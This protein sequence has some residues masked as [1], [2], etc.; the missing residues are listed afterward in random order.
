[1]PVHVHVCNVHTYIYI[2]IHALVVVVVVLAVVVV[3]VVIPAVQQ[4]GGLS[5]SVRYLQLTIGKFRA[6]LH[7]NGA[8]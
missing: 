2:Y 4:M 1:M 8:R 7:N 6:T 3:V 5:H